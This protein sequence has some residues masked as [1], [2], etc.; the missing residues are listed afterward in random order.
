MRYYKLIILTYLLLSLSLVGMGQTRDTIPFYKHHIGGQMNPLRKNHATYGMIYA[1]RYGYAFNPHLMV[2]AEF[3]YVFYEDMD[4]FEA[5]E[6]RLT[7]FGRYTF[8]RDRSVLPFAELGIYYMYTRWKDF[9]RSM[10]Y[11]HPNNSFVFESEN[12]KIRHLNTL[13]AYVAPGISINLYQ[14]RLRLDLMLRVNT[15]VFKRGYRQ[16]DATTPTYKVV[17]R[18]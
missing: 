8:M 18:F 15:D 5:N 2:G 14:H 7:A 6:L 3:A 4:R 11:W 10:H 9:A 13:K 17:Y 1:L 16:K 12:E